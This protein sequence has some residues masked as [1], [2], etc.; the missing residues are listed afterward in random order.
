M[1][2]IGLR[3]E[4]ATILYEDNQGALLMANAQRPTK[5]TR[6]M[7]IRHFTIQQWVAE[8][9]LCLRR[10][11]TAD[12]YSDSMTKALGRTLFYCHMNY[13][14]GRKI[15]EYLKATLNLCIKRFTDRTLF[16]NI[17]L[18]REGVIQRWLIPVG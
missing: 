17:R 16:D 4:A 3:Q 10:I 13:I 14:M 11:D 6:H 12:N 15:P 7:N 8:D 5:R 18:S 9:L 1:E 2:E